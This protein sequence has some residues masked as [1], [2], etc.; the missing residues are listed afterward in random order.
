MKVRMKR[1]KIHL[2]GI[3]EYDKRK[4]EKQYSTRF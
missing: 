2:M 4:W 1:C 3:S